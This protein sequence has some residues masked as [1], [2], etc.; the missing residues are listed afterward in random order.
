MRQEFWT[1]H[2]SMLARKL[3][4]ALHYQ[5]FAR[6]L[7]RSGGLWSYIHTNFDFVSKGYPDEMLD[8][9]N[10]MATP[11][12]NKRYLH[13]QFFVRWNAVPDR[14]TA[15][16]V[17]QLQKRLVISG[18]TTEEPEGFDKDQSQVVRPFGPWS[19]P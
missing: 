8:V 19:A 11:V 14:L 15:V 7:S 17:A 16:F 6:P 13:D 3:L 2:F 4:L 10:Q 12:R 9:A 1:P 18:I 5:C